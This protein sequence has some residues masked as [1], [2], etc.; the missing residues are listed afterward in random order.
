MHL[1]RMPAPEPAK[2]HCRQQF[3]FLYRIDFDDV[4]DFLEGRSACRSGHWVS[5]GPSTN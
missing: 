2:R 5:V 1:A 3:R 4:F